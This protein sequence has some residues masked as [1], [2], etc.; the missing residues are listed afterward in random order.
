M[1]TDN[2]TYFHTVAKLCATTCSTCHICL[3]LCQLTRIL[4][5]LVRKKLLADFTFQICCYFLPGTFYSFTQNSFW[6][7]TN[8]S[9]AHSSD[10]FQFKISDGFWQLFILFKT[11]HCQKQQY[12]P[13]RVE[14]SS[15]CVLEARQL[16][17]IADYLPTATCIQQPS[18]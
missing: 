4:C 14:S 7:N 5:S 2:R 9:P 17:L 10:F 16:I 18:P 8:S 11:K 3:V 15:P 6:R 12:R 1:V 13:A